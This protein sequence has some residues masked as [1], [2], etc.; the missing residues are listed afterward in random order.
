MLHYHTIGALLMAKII[1]STL[2][3]NLK[4]E[5]IKLKKVIAKAYNFLEC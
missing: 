2:T 1:P 4:Q 3:N 5:A